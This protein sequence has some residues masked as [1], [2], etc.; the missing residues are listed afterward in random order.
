MARTSAPR[1]LRSILER[2][3]TE[4]GAVS[5]VIGLGDAALALR[6]PEVSAWSVA[7]QVDHLVKVNQSIFSHLLTRTPASGPRISLAGRLVLLTGHFPRGRGE[8]PRK[9]RGQQASAVELAAAHE[10][11]RDTFRI[12]AAEPEPLLD[13]SAVLPHKMF[14][15]LTAAQALRFVP[16]H[17]RHH[18]RIVADIRAAVRRQH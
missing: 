11:S 8:S 12:L 10:K 9:L 7:E 4:L 17:T 1:N 5:S 16:I 14:G 2:I 13:P 18:L 3:E 6:A 15:A